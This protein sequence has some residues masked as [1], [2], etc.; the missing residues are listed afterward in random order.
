MDDRYRFLSTGIVWTAYAIVL[1]GLFFALIAGKPVL[2]ELGMTILGVFVLFLT[3][4]AG[5]TTSTIWRS[6]ERR[7]DASFGAQ[8]AGKVKRKLSDRV[9]RLL[10]QL[11]EDEIIELE[12]LLTVRQDERQ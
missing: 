1:V 6:A 8:E 9:G 3:A 5:I 4:V 11:D 10:E 12:T 7:A 2:D